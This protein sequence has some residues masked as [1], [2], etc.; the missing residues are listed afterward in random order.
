MKRI[1][2]LIQKLAG[3]ATKAAPLAIV[4]AGLFA[5]SPMVFAQCSFTWFSP[6]HVK[7]GQSFGPAGTL[8]S[9]QSG[10]VFYVFTQSGDFTLSSLLARYYG[11]VVGT[12]EKK[13]LNPFSINVGF[14]AIVPFS[15][16][17]GQTAQVTFVVRDIFFFQPLCSSSV[18]VIVDSN[19]GNPA[20]IQ[21]TFGVQGNFE[22]VMPYPSGGIAHYYRD[23]D[24]GD[25]NTWY[26]PTAVFGSGI[27][28]AVSLM[29]SSDGNLQVVARM[30]SQ[31][32]HFYRDSTSLNWSGPTFFA[33]GVSGT[34]SLIQVTNTNFEVVTP[35]AAG[36]MAHYTRT[37]NSVW[38]LVP[39]VFPSLPKVDAVSLIESDYANLEVVAR[40][41][42]RLAHFWRSQS[43]TWIGPYFFASGDSA[44]GTPSL[45]QGRFGTPGNF[46]VV[47]PLATGGMGHFYRDN[48][49]SSSPIWYGPSKFGSDNVGGAALIQ[50]N[51]GDNL[52]VVAC[53]ANSGLNHYYRS[54]NDWS[55]PAIIVP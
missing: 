32:A 44:S 14:S 19:C 37:G 54:F 52:E 34:P 28:D 43:K 27:V 36:G 30:G 8:T 11:L 26:G 22:V 40:I 55:G 38:T 23:N 9:S 45:I 48:S 31:L 29:E 7:P 49:P 12:G 6:V 5:A 21:S 2:Y 50:G 20:L 47:S 24:R 25:G 33:S 51:Y 35:L 1:N 42:D 17:P 39:D 16:K 18:T 10:V 3:I 4:M 13:I 15:A 41:G 53:V 46:E